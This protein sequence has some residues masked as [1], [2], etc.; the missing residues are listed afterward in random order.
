M[1]S[2]DRETLLRLYEVEKKTTP[3]IGLM[4]GCSATKIQR[5]LIHFGIQSRG[6]RECHNKE[7]EKRTCPGCNKKFEVG[8]RGRPKKNQRF[9][10]LHCRM[11]VENPSPNGH[12][13]HV[14]RPKK[15]KDTLH[16]AEWLRQK[17]EVEQLSALDIAKLLG[18]PS[19]TVKWA[20]N[21]WKIKVR[22]YNEAI[23]ILWD[24]RGRKDV[25]Q[26]DLIEG[27]GGKCACCG[28]TE[29]AFLT[30]DHIGGGGA[31]HRRSIK[32]GNKILRIRQELKAAGWPTDKYRLLCMNCNFA[33]RHGKVCP[34]QLKKENVMSEILDPVLSEDDLELIAWQWAGAAMLECK[35][36]DGLWQQW[37]KHA[38]ANIVAQQTTD[39]KVGKAFTAF[40]ESRKEK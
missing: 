16:N 12:S 7:P 33:T 11:V 37:V 26:A 25:T 8:G 13:S 23:K 20:L 4:L 24:R 1:N 21:K 36:V 40:V 2:I 3:E 27:Y 31:A 35:K 15:Y 18:C 17:Y 22:T 32:R 9:C 14:P 29:P 28:E 5:L 39:S 34:H 30:L 19:P 10:S 38:Q 6:A